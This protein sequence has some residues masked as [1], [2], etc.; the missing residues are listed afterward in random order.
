MKEQM[1]SQ[2]IAAVSVMRGPPLQEDAEVWGKVTERLIRENQR[3]RSRPDNI[4][5]SR[6]GSL[7]R[8]SSQ[9]GPA[10]RTNVRCRPET[11]SERTGEI[12]Q[13]LP[14][15]VGAVRKP[16]GLSSQ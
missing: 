14:Y 6:V 12:G 16:P 9:R 7:A 5:R 11:S 4:A 2:G 13:V 1:R 3:A 8:S 15:P 10:R